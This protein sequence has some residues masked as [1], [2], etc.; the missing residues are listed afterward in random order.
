MEYTHRGFDASKFQGKIDWKQAVKGMD[1]T[2][3]RA[4]YGRFSFQ[5]DPQFDANIKGASEAGIPVGVYWYSYAGS[6]KEAEE[7]ARVC[8]SVLEPYKEKI[9][10]PVFFDQEYEPAIL[11][12]GKSVRTA[13]AAAF[14]RK[15]KEAGYRPGMY[16]SLDWLKNKIERNALPEGTVVWCAR[17]GEN[18]PD[19]PH[20]VWQH[21]S[22][23]TVSGIEGKVDLNRASDAL[24]SAGV[25]SGW[26]KTPMGWRYGE[27]GEWV[28]ERWI[29]DKG[30]WYRMDKAGIALTGWEKVDGKWYYFL[31]AEDAGRTGYKECGCMEMAAGC[32]P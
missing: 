14:C 11:S 3:L 13:A 7:E 18:P 4:G 27:N 30:V 15:I 12:A 9:R 26:K 8:L 28:C 20:A 23:G 5:K 31:T 25:P 29:L 19:I 32:Q 6:E 22:T 24:F 16:G 10:L 17:Y 2:L 1:F 21:T